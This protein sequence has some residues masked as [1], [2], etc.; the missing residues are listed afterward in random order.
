MAPTKTRRSL[1]ACAVFAFSTLAAPAAFA[2]QSMISGLV[3]AGTGFEGGSPGEGVSW[4]RARTRAVGGLDFAV[5]E[6]GY[7]AF[8]FRAFVELERRATLGGSFF[9][10]RWVAPKFGLFAGCTGVA[11]P[12]HMFGGT[13]GALFLIGLGEKV[14]IFIEPSIAALPIGTDV[15]DGSV[16]VWALLSA[17]LRFDL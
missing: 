14:D 6:V 7:N 4:Q 11:A 9:Y 15:P 2:Q 1:T 5:D 17:G 3:G 16:I 13:A 12:E 8:G 10:T